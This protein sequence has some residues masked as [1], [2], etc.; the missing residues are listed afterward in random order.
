M[1]VNISINH[2]HVTLSITILDARLLLSKIM[3]DHPE[4]MRDLSGA[5]QQQEKALRSDSVL[6]FI[7]L[8]GVEGIT[9]SALLRKTQWMLKQDRDALLD[10]LIKSGKVKQSDKG[11]AHHPVRIYSFSDCG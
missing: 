10:G 4:A 11:L 1:N 6:K 8:A 5:I 9:H 2:D 7:K 3:D